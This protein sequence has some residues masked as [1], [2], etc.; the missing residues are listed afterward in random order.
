MSS[1]TSERAGLVIV[2]GGTS[3]HTC[4]KAFRE[5]GGSGP[6]TIVSDD[7]RPPY[8]R[9][10]LTKELITGDQGWDDLPLEEDGWWIE[11]GVTLRL[12]TTATTFDAHARTITTS[13]DTFA[14]DSLVLATGSSASTLPVP[15]ADG[16]RILRI[17]HA[18]DAARVLDELAGGGDVLIV[19]SGFVGCEIAASL[20]TRWP[21]RQ[22]ALATM[23]SAP[24]ADRLGDDVGAILAGWLDEHGVTVHRGVKLSS[25]E[26]DDGNSVVSFGDSL[27]LETRHVI[28]ATGARPNLDLAKAGG[29]ETEH[30][31]PVDA[32]MR[33][34]QDGVFAAGDIAHA[35]HPI[36]GR[37][38]RVE[39][40]GDAERMGEVAG[41]VAAGG[42]DEWRDV[43]GFWSVIGGRELK[44]VAWGD[45]YDESEVARS[46]DG[47]FT[48]WYAKGG[49][50]CGVLTYLHDEDHEAAAGLI[51]SRAPIPRR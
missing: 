46:D 37:R 44:Y 18:S 34:T 14:Y 28:M 38:L 7:D 8:F 22:V 13:H 6:I 43:P 35:M 26:R 27:R 32:S 9:P 2:G 15:G 42:H 1:S 47:G 25:I 24:Q 4:V 11:H 3:A 20:R 21:D 49:A 51:T 45:G 16:P 30:G 5:H 12:A 33:T 10:A 50:V 23:E 29:L 40:W 48:V 17:R 31:V 39:H 36:A 41:T 19:G